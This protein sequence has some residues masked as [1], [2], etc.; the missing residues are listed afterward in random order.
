MKLLGVFFSSFWS[1]DYFR[2]RV[3]PSSEVMWWIN[4]TWQWSFY[5]HKILCLITSISD[6]SKVDILTMIYCYL[7]QSGRLSRYGGG[8]RTRWLGCDFRLR[9]ETFLYTKTSTPALGPIHLNSSLGKGLTRV[10][11]MLKFQQFQCRIVLSSGI[12]RRVIWCMFTDVSE[13][14][15][16]PASSLNIYYINS[17]ENMKFSL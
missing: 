4:A 6:D 17:H 8:L 16:R 14:C 10:T 12:R 9:K 5:F 1:Q 13:G 3:F 7:D 15:T 11:E 2:F